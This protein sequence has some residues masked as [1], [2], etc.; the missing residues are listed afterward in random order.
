MVGRSKDLGG[1][2]VL[3]LEKFRRALRLRWP[4]LQWNAP[5][6]PLLGSELPCKNKDMDFF[7]AATTICIENGGKASFWLDRW[8]AGKASKDIMPSII[9]LARHQRMTVMLSMN[10]GPL[11]L[12]SKVC[13][14]RK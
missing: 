9:E 3:D 2:G 12:R 8:F 4:W 13:R 11:I 14:R 5:G 7:R 6:R 1:L 10:N